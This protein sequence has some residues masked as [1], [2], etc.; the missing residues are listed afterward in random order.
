[1]SDK[2]YVFIIRRLIAPPRAPHSLS[3]FIPDTACFSNGEPRLI[4]FSHKD[5]RLSSVQIKCIRQKEKLTLAQIRKFFNDRR[6]KYREFIDMCLNKTQSQIQGFD[7]SMLLKT[8]SSNQTNEARTSKPRRL[9]GNAVQLKLV[10]KQDQETQ[11][12]HLEKNSKEAVVCKYE[13]ENAQI[14]NEVEFLNLMM[15]RKAD[16]V[17]SKIQYV[18]NFVRPRKYAF[19]IHRVL[20]RAIIGRLQ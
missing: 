9:V 18:Q 1:M 7:D 14:M 5:R 8:Q 13:D 11:E 12:Q 3:I 6:K 2:D 4:A 16:P 15:R 19:E 20:P 10:L 17:W